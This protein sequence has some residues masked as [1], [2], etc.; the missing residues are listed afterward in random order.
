MSLFG[1]EEPQHVTI[2][3]G[4]RLACLVC[5]DE[6]F[7]LRKGQLNTAVASFFRLDWA[8]P[9]ANCVVCGRCGYVHWFLESKDGA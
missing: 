3:N 7:F 6:R 2:R 4:E 9:S 8:N 1:K 5:G